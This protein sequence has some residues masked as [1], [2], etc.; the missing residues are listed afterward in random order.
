MGP[1]EHLDQDL[2]PCVHAKSILSN[3]IGPIGFV[4][5]HRAVSI[6][7]PRA[8]PGAFSH[9]PPPIRCVGSQRL[10]KMWLSDNILRRPRDDRASDRCSYPSDTLARA[11]ETYNTAQAESRDYGLLFYRLY[12]RFQL[13]IPQVSINLPSPI[14]R[15]G[16]NLAT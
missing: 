14:G 9:M 5:P 6:L 15:R 11:L 13:S 10:R 2:C 12:V 3:G 1:G 7:R 16:P 4:T 8:L